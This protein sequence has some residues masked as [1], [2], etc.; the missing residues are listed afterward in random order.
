[1]RE[2]K[3]APPANQ[4]KPHPQQQE[5]PF[6]PNETLRLCDH[7]AGDVSGDVDIGGYVEL[8]RGGGGGERG[9]TF[10]VL[11]LRFPSPVCD[12]LYGLRQPCC[13]MG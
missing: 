8:R 2:K 9:Y 13:D 12:I 1:M 5:L 6:V 3:E 10:T 4:R 7:Q 11:F